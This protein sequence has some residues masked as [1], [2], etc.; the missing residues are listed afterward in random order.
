VP[1]GLSQI[2]ERSRKKP[3]FATEQAQHKRQ[4][5]GKVPPTSSGIEGDHPKAPAKPP[6]REPAGAHTI[7]IRYDDKTLKV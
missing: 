6:K 2:K 1:L 5:A 7:E 3:D 4:P